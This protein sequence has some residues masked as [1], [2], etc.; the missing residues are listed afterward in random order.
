MAAR[1]IMNTIA[2]APRVD[3]IKM[4]FCQRLSFPQMIAPRI[5]NRKRFNEFGQ[6]IVSFGNTACCPMRSLSGLLSRHLNRMLR[7]ESR[8]EIG[9]R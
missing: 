8:G 7:G 4:A 9:E 1:F 6:G 3:R 5:G 2:A